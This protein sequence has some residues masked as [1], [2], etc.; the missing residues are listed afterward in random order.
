MKKILLITGLI[1]VSKLLHGQSIIFGDWIVRTKFG[2]EKHDKR[3]F[4][5]ALKEQL[6]AE[7]YDKQWG[8]YQIELL[9]QRMIMASGIIGVYGGFGLNYEVA[10]F[11]RPFDHKYFIE[12]GSDD[13]LLLQDRYHKVKAPIN[14]NSFFR[15]SERLSV[16]A[17]IELN[18]LIQRSIIDSRVSNA[19]FPYTEARFE[20]DDIQLRLGVNYRSG[21]FIIGLRSRVANFQK[22]DRVIFNRIVK[23]P[24]T[25]QTWEWYNPLRFDL[26]VGYTW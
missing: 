25:D 24:R 3:L 4:D 13:I 2:I 20:L 17:E 14:I 16:S 6:L 26:T 19:G 11:R 22:I 12:G 7:Q 23:D 8:T 9:L 15:M 18:W 21:N 1:L 10:S 5:Y